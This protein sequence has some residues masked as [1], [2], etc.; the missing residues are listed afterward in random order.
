MHY[1]I[2]VFTA[3][4]AALLGCSDYHT[5]H[6]AT[7]NGPQHPNPAEVI[8]AGLPECEGANWWD[9]VKT[10]PIETPRYGDGTCILGGFYTDLSDAEPTLPDPCHAHA[11]LIEYLDGG[12]PIAVIER[13]PRS[14]DLSFTEFVPG[15]ENTME[16]S[17]SI[18]G[19]PTWIKYVEDDGETRE[20]IVDDPKDGVEY[21]DT[22]FFRMDEIA[23]RTHTSKDKDGLT[24]GPD[25]YWCTTKVFM[26][27]DDV[28]LD[29]PPEPQPDSLC[30]L[31][32]HI[33]SSD[34]TSEFVGEFQTDGR[35]RSWEKFERNQH[36]QILRQTS[37]NGSVE[38][39][40]YTDKGQVKVHTVDQ[41]GKGVYL[42]EEYEYV[43]NEDEGAVRLYQS[44]PMG[45]V[46]RHLFMIDTYRDRRLVEKEI[47]RDTLDSYHEDI[48]GPYPQEPWFSGSFTSEPTWRYQVEFNTRG[49]KVRE[50]IY[51][52]S[53]SLQEDMPFEERTWEY[54]SEGRMTRDSYQVNI[55][56]TWD[57]Y[58]QALG[59]SIIFNS[60]EYD[61][62]DHHYEYYN[63][64]QV[65]RRTI[66]G[67]VGEAT[68]WFDYRYHCN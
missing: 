21:T 2:R 60:A 62:W 18:G 16:L 13:Q 28:N 35:Y 37:S 50:A 43:G 40:T 63:S 32:V 23:R 39:F 61:G 59:G 4:V 10:Y 5:N 41:Y 30:E 15:G 9:E 11:I 51:V 12:T 56:S 66:N 58:P 24:K 38:T 8:E 26:E 14:D 57:H 7:D 68:I 54:N 67:P 52:G 49:D 17:L 27:M 47:Y 48:M 20:V 53:A 3:L 44:F 25:S 55:L 65:K 22:H 33:T 46:D 45:S 42:V 34:H 6:D 36:G 64:G 29:M 31:E 1:R 19:K